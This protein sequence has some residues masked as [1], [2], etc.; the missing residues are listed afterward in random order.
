MLNGFV[1]CSIHK[2][3]R[4][5][6]KLSLSLCIALFVAVPNASF[7]QPDC[8]I[9]LTSN[10]STGAGIYMCVTTNVPQWQNNCGCSDAAKK[11]RYYHIRNNLLCD[12]KI[13][14]VGIP[15]RKD[16]SS[17]KWSVCHPM[18]NFGT[19]CFTSEY[20]LS[21]LNAS[22][23]AQLPGVCNNFYAVPPE[24]EFVTF[25]PP[26]SAPSG[27][28]DPN[29]ANWF[30]PVGDHFSFVLCGADDGT[31]Y[32]DDDPLIGDVAGVDITLTFEWVSG[33]VPHIFQQEYGN[34]SLT[35]KCDHDR[36]CDH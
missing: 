30:I 21:V 19:D 20:T 34:V 9:T 25:I 26:S 6:L 2:S 28:S 13:T 3:L 33:G 7:A 17:T 18:K 22:P 1:S 23:Q 15:F 5:W 24:E 31:T 35:N 14:Q 32:S 27:C 11:C 16:P 8:P 12:V 4:L 36:N 29:D 10:E